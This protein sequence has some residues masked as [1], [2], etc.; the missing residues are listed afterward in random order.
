MSVLSK[1]NKILLS[2]IIVAIIT[3]FISPIPNFTAV[4][5]VALFSGLKFDNKYLALTAPLIVMIIS[6]LFLGFF[7]VTPIVYFA[8]VTVSIIGV[9]SKKFLNLNE[10]KSQRYSIYLVSVIAGSCTFFAITNFGVWLL[11][12]PM[13]IEGFITCFTLA[14]PFFQSSILADL[15][16]SSVLIFGF[17]LANAQS[18]LANLQ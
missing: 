10:S 13:N 3:R 12:Y 1:K 7:L 6:D 17:D 18:K 5:A 11:Y 8:F 16:F 14:I 15:F 2:F 9:Y 4:T